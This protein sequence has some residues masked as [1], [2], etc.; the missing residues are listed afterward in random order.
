MENNI[1]NKTSPNQMRIFMQRMRD[2]KY[3]VN[4]TQQDTP[5]KNL[6]VRDMLKITRSRKINEDVLPT[7]GQSEE[8]SE[9]DN[10]VEPVQ[11][12]KTAYDQATEEEKFRNYFSDMNVDIKFIDLKV[13]DNLVFWG[14]TI[15][16]VIQ[17]VYKVTPDEKTTGIEFNYLPDFTADNPD[18]DLIIEKIESY[19]DVF[20]KFWRDNI[21]QSK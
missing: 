7:A 1:N 15:D 8:T 16:G 20:Y 19:F 13:Y 17:F 11:N 18:N 3:K 10:T 12:K 2:G 6:T 5:A 21:L 4:E 9:D 14:G